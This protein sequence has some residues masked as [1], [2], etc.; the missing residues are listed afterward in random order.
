MMKMVRIARYFHKIRIMKKEYWDVTDE[1]IV[2]KNR[3]A[4]CRLDTET[5]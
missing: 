5:V 1:Q 4:H 3:K 2:E